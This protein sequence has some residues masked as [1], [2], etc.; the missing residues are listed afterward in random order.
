MSL[1]MMKSLFSYKAWANV[2]LF[3]VLETLRQEDGL[4]TA[5]RTMNHIYVVDRIFRAHLLNQPHGHDAT[6]TKSTP[7][8]VTLRDAVAE[9]DSW[10][11]EYVDTLSDAALVERVRFSFTD[12][13]AGVMSRE[14]MLMHVIVH[15][16]YHRG[17]VGQILKVAAIAPPRDLLT[18]FL[19]VTEP[20][21]RD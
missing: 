12:G 9:T 16:G 14:E 17:N 10:F 1:L 13:D 7:A 15:G 8:L 21:R 19:H 6:N 3:D 4:R 5:I 20:E 18:R 2:E 11:L